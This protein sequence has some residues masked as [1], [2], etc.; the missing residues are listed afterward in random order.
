M[1]NHNGINNI[2]VVVFIILEPNY[3]FLERIGCQIINQLRFSVQIFK[4]I[5]FCFA[6]EVSEVR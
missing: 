6:I 4:R 1:N 2:L 3:N 5:E